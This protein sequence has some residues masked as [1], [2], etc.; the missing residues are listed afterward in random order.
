MTTSSEIVS[1]FSLPGP[2]SHVSQAIIPAT[3]VVNVGLCK[4][5]FG[6]AGG[7]IQVEYVSGPSIQFDQMKDNVWHNAMGNA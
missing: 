2:F 6:G 3:C 1:T 7:G 4:P 5:L